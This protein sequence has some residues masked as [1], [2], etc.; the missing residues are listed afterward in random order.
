MDI[1]T[2]I[3]FVKCGIPADGLVERLN[4]IPKMKIAGNLELGKNH[5]SEALSYYIGF[6]QCAHL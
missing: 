5:S 2:C 3:P 4:H 1:G 6:S